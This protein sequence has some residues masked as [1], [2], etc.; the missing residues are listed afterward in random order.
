MI[1]IVFTLIAMNHLPSN[2]GEEN[3]G[4]DK[5]NGWLAEEDIREKKHRGLRGIYVGSSS[6]L[7]IHYMNIRKDIIIYMRGL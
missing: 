5:A 6:Q 3:S 4:K 7:A 2:S 1:R